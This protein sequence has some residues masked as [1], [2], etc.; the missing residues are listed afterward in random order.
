MQQYQDTCTF[1]VQATPRLAYQDALLRG[2][3]SFDPQ[4]PKWQG[5]WYYAGQQDGR[6]QFRSLHD[7]ELLP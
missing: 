2:R 3:L 7:G 5:H 6:P 4:S 1:E